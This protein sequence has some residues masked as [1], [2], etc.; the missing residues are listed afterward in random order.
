[1]IKKLSFKAAED[2]FIV[3]TDQLLHSVQFSRPG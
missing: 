2:F 1:M 3:I